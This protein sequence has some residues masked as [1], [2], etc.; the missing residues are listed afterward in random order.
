MSDIK[1]FK[2]GIYLSTRVG[3]MY[4]QTGKKPLLFPEV[5]ILRQG[6]GRGRQGGGKGWLVDVV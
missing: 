4:L 6:V 3:N 2:F 1:R 5:G